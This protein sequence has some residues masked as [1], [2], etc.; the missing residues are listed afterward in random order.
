MAKKFHKRKEEKSTFKK[1][2]DVIKKANENEKIKSENKKTEKQKSKPKGYRAKRMGVYSFWL[3]F[4]L[5]FLFVVIN[6]IS[7]NSKVSAVDDG[8][9]GEVIVNH[10]SSQEAIEFGKDFLHEYFTW[11]VNADTEEREATMSTYMTEDLINR[12]TSGITT[13]DWNASLDRNDMILV[14]SEDIGTDKA[15]LTY[16][17]DLIFNKT[18]DAIEEEQQAN[19]AQQTSQTANNGQQQQ[20]NNGQSQPQSNSGQQHQQSNA[21]QQQSQA[22]QI[23]KQKQTERYVTVHIYYDAETNS[24]V[25]YQLPS[26]THVENETSNVNVESPTADMEELRGNEASEV[27]EFLDVFF[28]SYA[29]DTEG[30]LRYLVEDED[31]QNGLNGSMRFVSVNNPKV[32]AGRTD[33][34]RVVQTNVTFREPETDIEFNSDYLLVLDKNDSGYYVTDV[35]DVAYVE[36]ISSGKEDKSEDEPEE[37]SGTDEETTEQQGNTDAEESK[38]EQEESNDNSGE[39]TDNST[40]EE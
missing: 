26:F 1:A 6:S 16:Q 32:Y 12:N 34:E 38:D 2:I 3:V 10:A 30:T 19:T 25:V 11:D 14:D 40:N 35:N 5:L 15:Q 33:T 36:Q 7:L 23:Q 22:N 37:E 24:F 8:S 13:E 9:E 4:G 20:S 39:G 31:Y 21:G 17:I 29:H 28:E 27:I 18:Q